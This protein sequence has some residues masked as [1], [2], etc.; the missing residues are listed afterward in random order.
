MVV[1]VALSMIGSAV[2]GSI[3]QCKAQLLVG[4]ALI[5]GG[6]LEVD[7]DQVDT[8]LNCTE[9]MVLGLGLRMNEQDTIGWTATLLRSLC[10][11]LR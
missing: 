5:V 1:A 9:S 4:S 2:V 7:A 10:C 3:Q 11:G 6:S 8:R